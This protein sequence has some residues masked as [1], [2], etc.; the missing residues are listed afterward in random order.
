[1]MRLIA[2]CLAIVCLWIA[3][4]SALPPPADPPEEVLR[5]EIITEAR[6]P[7]DGQPV[8]PAEYARLQEELSDRGLPI[9]SRRVSNTIRLLR[10]R[11]AIRSLF[12]FLLP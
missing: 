8:S 4:V 10:I 12:P 3:P 5:T 7:V 9:L 1:M 2:A 11:Q 6:S